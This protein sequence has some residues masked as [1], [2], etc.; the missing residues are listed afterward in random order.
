M[1]DGTVVVTGGTR[2]I[3]R[4]VVERFAAT[5]S[6]VLASSRDAE[7]LADL[8][9]ATDGA[10][11][12][13]RADARDEFD[14]ERLM[15]TGARFGP[16]GI[17]LVV[18]CATVLHGELGETPR[19]GES[20]AAFDDTLRTN[21]RGVFTAIKE[22]LPHMPADGRAV[23][24]TTAVARQVSRGSGAYAVSKAATEAVVRGFAADSQQAV[25]CVDP[26]QVATAAT[27]HEGNAPE[28]AARMVE[29][30]ATEVAA[31]ALNGAVLRIDEYRQTVDH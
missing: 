27:G 26:G 9:E 30:A 15:E 17:D 12:S 23:V 8:L 20:Y 2:G 18:P 3:G 7:D 5:G 24:P 28:E 6:R 21:T 10:V 1:Q 11:R 19:V 13:L 16:G 31:E 14:V 4:A 29:W 25:G 22:A